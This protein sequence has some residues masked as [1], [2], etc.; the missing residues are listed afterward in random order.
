MKFIDLPAKKQQD[1]IK[2]MFDET[3]IPEQI[4][5]KDWWLK[6]SL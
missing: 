6:A 2:A 3:D 5:E 1:F 4:I